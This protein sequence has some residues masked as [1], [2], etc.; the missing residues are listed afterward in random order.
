MSAAPAI[1]FPG[2]D[3]PGGAAVL[4]R[5]G[6]PVT[7]ELASWAA[8]R[9]RPTEK[10]TAR[11]VEAGLAELLST[12]FLA[13]GVSRGDLVSVTAGPV[14]WTVSGI[15]ARTGVTALRVVGGSRE[16][17]APLVSQLAG[18]GVVAVRHR[19]LP[20]VVVELPPGRD[21][22]VAIDTVERLVGCPVGVE[23]SCHRG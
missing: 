15:E 9:P 21:V 6:V 19:D 10:V 16:E 14:G 20:I 3:L 13:S 7:F 23:V 11:I 5:V 18:T 4:S 22:A 17:L 8:W 1:G 12:P 2:L